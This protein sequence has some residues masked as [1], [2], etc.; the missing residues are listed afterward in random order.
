MTRFAAKTPLASATRVIIGAQQPHQDGPIAPVKAPG[1]KDAE[2]NAIAV[3][4]L[5]LHLG[6]DI[7]GTSEAKRFVWYSDDLAGDPI[8]IYHR[9]AITMVIDQGFDTMEGASG[10]DWVSATQSMRARMPL[11]CDHL[12][13]PGDVQRL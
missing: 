11:R 2:R 3:K 5:M 6:T 7:V 4:T 12:Q 13:K 8:E 1:S 9:H 10:D